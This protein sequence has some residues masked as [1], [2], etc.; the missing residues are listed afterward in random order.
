M[1]IITERFGKRIRTNHYF[2][3]GQVLNDLELKTMFNQLI[4]INEKKDQPIKHKLIDKTYS[5]ETIRNIYRNVIVGILFVDDSPVGFLIS[6][7]L[8]GLELNI[9]H[10]GLTVISKNHGDNLLGLLSLGLARVIAMKFKKAYVTN[11]SSTPSILE[12]FAKFTAKTWPDPDAKLTRAPKNYS[13]VFDILFDTYIYKYFENPDQ[14]L[15]DKKRFVIQSSSKKMGFNTNLRQLSRSTNFKY[16]SFCF[17][18]LDYEKEEDLVQIG[19][20]DFMMG[21]KIKTIFYFLKFV[22]F[23]LAERKSARM[24]N[25]REEQDNK[26]IIKFHK[27]K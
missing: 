20:I 19:V 22:I 12:N 9:V 23:P 25:F 1:N 17:T 4:E 15:K 13:K 27:I 24:E 16:L 5:L 2:N 8:L 11:I 3:P 7:I 21:L 6:P 14:V 10:A 18:W 26:R